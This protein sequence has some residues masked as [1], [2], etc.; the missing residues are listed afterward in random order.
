MGQRQWIAVGAMFAVAMSAVVA[1]LFARGHL[2][3]RNGPGA[4]VEHGSA[5]KVTVRMLS[6]PI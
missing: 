6:E 4:E 5:E 2:H 1:V 3:G